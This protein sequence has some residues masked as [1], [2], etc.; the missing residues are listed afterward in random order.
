M[1]GYLQVNKV[2]LTRL[3][4]GIL[5]SVVLAPR[6]VMA[7]GYDS[8]R[9]DFYQP[10]PPAIGIH[11]K[12]GYEGQ[13]IL[14]AAKVDLGQNTVTLPL[15]KGQL[16]DGRSVWY[17][18][19]DVSDEGV[20]RQTGLNY[21][22]KLAN[23]R[24]SAVRTA[25]WNNDGTL[26]FDKG[27]VD[28][29]PERVL[30]PGDAP[31]FFPPKEARAGSVGDEFYTPLVRVGDLVYN[32]TTVAFNVDASEIEFPDGKVDYSKV[33]DRAVAI[34]PANGTVTFS[35][36]LGSVDG[37][38]IVFISLESNDMF[39]SAAEATTYTPALS[40]VSF[41]LNDSANSVVAVNYIMINGPTGEGNPQIQGVN[42]ALSDKGG[43]VLDVFDSAPGVRDGYS[44]MWD[45]YLGW[46]T[47]EAIDKGYRAAVQ[48]ELEWLTLVEKGWITGADGGAMGTVKLVSNCPLIMHW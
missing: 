43:Q 38:P 2:R 4:L 46:W 9:H 34:S 33:L 31:D 42:S 21:A 25:R 8:F 13:Q 27:T 41:G 10:T 36:N 23:A 18:L 17:V 15:Y 32:A 16:E 26:I 3:A 11:H 1:K 20:A 12:F 48:S 19:T 29:S 6:L 40:G 44:P 45:L 22:P 39:V 30:T 28:F 14:Q 24:G 37:H 47:Q 35:L 5:W 7:N